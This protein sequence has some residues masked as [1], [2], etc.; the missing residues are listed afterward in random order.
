[1]KIEF[2][3]EHK[4]D[5]ERGRVTFIAYVDGKT[6]RNTV[7]EEALADYFIDDSSSGSEE[8]YLR[9]RVTIDGIAK[10]MIE[11]GLTNA[12]GGAD[13]GTEEVE[14]YGRAADEA[15]GIYHPY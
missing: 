10:I 8:T 7:S 3:G 11:A 15:A 9:R 12:S 14:R 5:I 2:S 13:I 1:M 4:F 6:V